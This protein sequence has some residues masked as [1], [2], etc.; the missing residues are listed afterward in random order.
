[1]GTYGIFLNCGQCR[2]YIISR[3]TPNGLLQSQT[4]RPSQASTLSVEC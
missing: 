4:I 1:M 2:I 3:I